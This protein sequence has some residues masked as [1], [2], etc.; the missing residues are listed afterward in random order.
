MPLRIQ[1]DVK[2]IEGVLNEILN[3]LRPPVGR[4]RLLSSGF[5][6]GHA[7]NI[8]EDISGHKECLACGNCVDICPILVREPSRR[9]KTEQRTSMALESIVGEDC[10]LCDACILACPQVDTTIKNYVVNHRMI[11]V[12][13]RLEKR[14]GDEDEPDLDLFLEE[15]LSQA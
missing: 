12:M 7:L 3:T 10:D 6:P 11:E 15:A 14:I 1:Q 4:C 8:T 9:E 2:E 13:S 5:N